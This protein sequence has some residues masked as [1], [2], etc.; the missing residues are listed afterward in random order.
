[1]LQTLC[2]EVLVKLQRRHDVR[3]PSCN[4]CGN[5]AAAAMMQDC[6]ASLHQL[7]VGNSGLLQ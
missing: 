6:C 5:S 2:P 3:H 1:M 7:V 4:S